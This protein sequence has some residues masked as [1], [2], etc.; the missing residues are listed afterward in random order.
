MP[1][2]PTHYPVSVE[3]QGAGSSESAGG[4]PAGARQPDRPA[5]IPAAG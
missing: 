3:R 5:H 4:H 2:A 1:Q